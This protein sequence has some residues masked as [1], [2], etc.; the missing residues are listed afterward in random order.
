MLISVSKDVVGKELMRKEWL[1][2][3]EE[4][5]IWWREVFCGRVGFQFVDDNLAAT[6]SS[7]CPNGRL[8]RSSNCRLHG[9]VRAFVDDAVAILRSALGRCRIT[10]NSTLPDNVLGGINRARLMRAQIDTAERDKGRASQT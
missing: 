8:N 5:D 1:N 2:S 4:R 9:A 10:L 3:V 7:G 6:R